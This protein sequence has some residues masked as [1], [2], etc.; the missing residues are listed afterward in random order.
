MK[1]KANSVYILMLFLISVVG[2]SQIKLPQI[3]N[4]GMVLQRDTNLKLWGWADANQEITLNFNGEI[5][6][7]TSNSNSEW[8]ILLPSQKYGG[9]YEMIFTAEDSITLTDIYFGDVWLCSGQSNMETTMERVSPLYPEII[10][11]SENN[12]IRQFLVPDEYNFKEPSKDV[13][14]GDWKIA[15]PDNLKQFSALAYFFALDLYNKTGIPMG[16]I[17]SAVG[18]SPINAWLDAGS[19]R[20]F[21]EMYDEHKKYQNDSLI[22]AIEKEN[23]LIFSQWNE[24]LTN[25]D[26]GYSSDYLNADYSNWE[27]TEIPGYWKD[28][29]IT[30][31]AGV[32]WY[33]K[34]I[35]LLKVPEN[36]ISELS[37]GRLI[38]SDQAYING[39]LVGSTGYQYPPR[40]YKFDSKILKR[41]KNV[42]TLRLVNNGGQ[43]G[44]VEDKPYFLEVDNDSIDIQG[45]W[46]V[47]L[48]ATM[49]NMKSQTS[50]RFKPGGLHNAM[51]APFYNYKIAGILWYQGES[52]AGNPEM[53]SKLFPELI[54]SWRSL[55]NDDELPFLYVQ[56][57]NFMKFKEEPGESNWAEMREVQRKTKIDLKNTG[58]AVTIDIG[59][60][61]DIHPL[62]KKD[63]GKR[64]ARHAR[65]LVYNEELVAESPEPTSSEVKGNVVFIHFANVGKGLKTSEN[66][67]PLSFAI[68]ENGKDFFIAKAKIVGEATV[69]ITT[70]K[71][72]KPVYIRYAWADN[73]ENAN[74]YNSENLPASPFQISVT[75]NK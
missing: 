64:L 68:S 59:E 73:P 58:M 27:S 7:T 4:N 38:D 2:H 67:R 19:L 15:N 23:S 49:P 21:P 36:A 74:L 3:I 34:E 39:E 6:S 26:K 12:K 13:S 30:D 31:S 63:V 24:V 61:N 14:G 28:I 69:K 40:R 20:K 65:K 9:P 57:P 53:Y 1:L 75:N 50:V 71:V 43:A 10:A 60:W 52:D 11:N 37:L 5:F 8:E 47:K 48:G 41:G 18:G 22:N 29:K 51:I 66:D 17:N 42:I 62:N 56:L 25:L 32:V 70:N 35:T 72:I 45:E 16:L 33:K 55:W 46:K 54:N 44:F